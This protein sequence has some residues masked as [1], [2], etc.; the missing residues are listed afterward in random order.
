[1]LKNVLWVSNSFGQKDGAPLLPAVRTVVEDFAIL[2]DGGI[3]G[4]RNKLLVFRPPAEA[5]V[6]F[7]KV[8]VAELALIARQLA[9]LS[10]RIHV[11]AVVAVSFKITSTP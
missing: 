6:F 11:V 2:V 4:A 7:R 1:L 3:V 8:F 10:A 5:V 9:A